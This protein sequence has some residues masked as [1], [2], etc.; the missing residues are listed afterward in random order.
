MSSYQKMTM[1]IQ[2]E[3][4][5]SNG[6]DIAFRDIESGKL[7]P[8]HNQCQ[9]SIAETKRGLEASVVVLLTR[10]SD[11]QC[12]ELSIGDDKGKLA[13]ISLDGEK[14]PTVE[15]IN[16]LSTDMAACTI[17]IDSVVANSYTGSVINRKDLTAAGRILVDGAIVNGEPA[18]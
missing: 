1:K 9:M 13:I 8:V 3:G 6:W 10:F 16:Q 14:L 12:I 7:L 18:G 2:I 15:E 5:G 17:L 11:A 4:N